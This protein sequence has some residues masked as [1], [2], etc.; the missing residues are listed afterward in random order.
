[1]YEDGDHI[2]CAVFD[3]LFWAIL[4]SLWWRAIA[5]QSYIVCMMNLELAFC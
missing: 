3:R 1:M 2:N 4:L 5:F